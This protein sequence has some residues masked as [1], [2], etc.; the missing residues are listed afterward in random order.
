MPGVAEPSGLAF[1]P[2]LERWFVVGDEGSLAELDHDGVVLRVDK[3]PGNLEGVAVHGPSGRVLLLAERTS[4]IVVWDPV[5][6]R[7]ERRIRLDRAALLGRAEG[8]ANN[9]FEGIAFREQGDGAAR[10]T[11]PTS[12]RPAM[13]VAL[14][15]RP[16]ARRRRAGRRGRHR[17]AGRWPDAATSPTSRTRARSTGCWSSRTRRTCCS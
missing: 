7:E 8:D 2:T 5:A 13:V 6:H 17:A 1:H 9:G 3:V 15:L 14:T 12:A 10:S 4:E 11:S 16:G